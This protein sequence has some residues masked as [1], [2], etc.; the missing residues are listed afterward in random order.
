MKLKILPRKKMVGRRRNGAQLMW[1]N[2][3]RQ[4]RISITM[5]LLGFCRKA[6][7]TATTEEGDS[8]GKREIDWVPIFFAT[9]YSVY[10]L[11]STLFSV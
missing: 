4:F 7:A 1:T 10:F 5:L 8:E 3:G 2:P 11:L 9:I 6:N